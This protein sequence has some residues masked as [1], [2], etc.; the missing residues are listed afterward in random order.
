MK[1]CLLLYRITKSM[2]S[3]E[4]DRHVSPCPHQQHIFAT[5]MTAEKFTNIVHLTKKINKLKLNMDHDRCRSKLNWRVNSKLKPY[6]SSNCHVSIVFLIQTT[7][8]FPSKL[9]FLFHA[10][11]RDQ[12]TLSEFFFSVKICYQLMIFAQSNAV[13]SFLLIGSL[14]LLSTCW[15]CAGGHSRGLKK[16]THKM[17]FSLSSL[18]H[19]F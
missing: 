5:W 4:H 19:L 17:E 8:F 7:N 14:A 16:A 15:S 1:L 18:Y 9:P 13:R 3:L 2:V 12:P 10:E 11:I 6:L